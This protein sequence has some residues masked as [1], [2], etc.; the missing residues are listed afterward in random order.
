M[1]RKEGFI[2]VGGWFSLVQELFTILFQ[3]VIQILV[4]FFPSVTNKFIAFLLAIHFVLLQS[5]TSK[6]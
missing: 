4:C 2:L 6:Y 1:L 3:D 5:L